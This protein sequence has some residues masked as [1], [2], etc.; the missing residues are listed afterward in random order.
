L[1]LPLGGNG[2]AKTMQQNTGKCGSSGQ[3]ANTVD[4]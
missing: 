4:P 2:T 3:P 1:T